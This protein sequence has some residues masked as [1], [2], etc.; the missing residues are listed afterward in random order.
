MSAPEAEPVAEMRVD[1]MI[2]LPNSIPTGTTERG[3]VD[4]VATN[5][6]DTKFR[7]AEAIPSMT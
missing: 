7:A 2:V 6:P 4:N 3:Q 5:R 1:T